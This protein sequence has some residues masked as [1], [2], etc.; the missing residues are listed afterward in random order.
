MM[1]EREIGHHCSCCGDWIPGENTDTGWG[2]CL[3]CAGI[4]EEYLKPT[5]LRITKLEKVAQAA[6]QITHAF[7]RKGRCYI[8]GSGE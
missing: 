5:E 7:S 3:S 1:E 8:S 6:R 4:T 2:L